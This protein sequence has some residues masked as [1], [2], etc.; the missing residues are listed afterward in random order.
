METKGS[1]RSDKPRRTPL[2]GVSRPANIQRTDN[3]V[4]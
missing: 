3:R 1:E 4:L 2:L